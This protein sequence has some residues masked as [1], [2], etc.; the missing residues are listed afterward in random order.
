MESLSSESFNYEHVEYIVECDAS[1]DGEVSAAGWNIFGNSS[2]KDMME[3]SLILNFNSTTKCEIQS[4]IIALEE[5]SE[6]TDESSTSIIV[7]TDY[8]GVIKKLED[9][10]QHNSQVK[11]LQESLSKFE[12]WSIECVNRDKLTRAHDLAKYAICEYR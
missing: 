2:Q 9:K 10:N 1:Y 7:R 3:G 5:L 12:S 11:E 6:A 4:I 8:L